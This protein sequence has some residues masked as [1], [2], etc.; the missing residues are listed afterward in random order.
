MVLAK[1]FSLCGLLDG[2]R[3]EHLRELGPDGVPTLRVG[4]VI[5][6]L[7]ERCIAFDGSLDGPAHGRVCRQVGV[8]LQDV[9]AQQNPVLSTEHSRGD[10]RICRP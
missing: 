7:C 6:R 5:E 8:N 3:S 2:C 4:N 10:D 1:V 9:G